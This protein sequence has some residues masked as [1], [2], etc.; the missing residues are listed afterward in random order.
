MNFYKVIITLL[1]TSTFASA[2]ETVFKSWRTFQNDY[3]F[4]F[5]YP[6][7][8]KVIS[9]DIDGEGPLIRHAGVSVEEAGSCISPRKQQWVTNGIGFTPI[10]EKMKKLAMISSANASEKSAQYKIKN[11]DWV[12]F[13][14][15]KINGDTEVIGYVEHLTMKSPDFI[16]WNYEIYCDTRLIVAGGAS[17]D[18]PSKE[19]LDNIRKQDDLAISEPYKT[20]IESFRCTAPKL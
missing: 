4:E 8:W 9:N 6:D 11:G 7:C 2:N 19:L 5:K 12:G 1:F 17:I 20:I 16:R 13:R 15:F 10:K 3:G 18:N 14:R